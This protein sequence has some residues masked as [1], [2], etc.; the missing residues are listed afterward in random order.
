MQMPELVAVFLGRNDVPYPRNDLGAIFDVDYHGG[1]NQPLGRPFFGLSPKFLDPVVARLIYI[2]NIPDPRHNLTSKSKG[3]QPIASQT[4]AFVKAARE[5]GCDQSEA[6]FDEKLKKVARHKP[7]EPKA[8][9]GQA[10]TRK[11]GGF[12]FGC[13]KNE[14]LPTSWHL[15][16]K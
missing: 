3:D 5:L 7:P 2:G 15:P 1:D 9:P 6:T 13:C 12:F 16:C 4:E 14:I 11:I 10:Q 8:K